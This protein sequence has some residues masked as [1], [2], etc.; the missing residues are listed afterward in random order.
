MLR[1][2]LRLGSPAPGAP[3]AGIRQSR[4]QHPQAAPSAAAH[5][6]R[7]A[8][9][10]DPCQAPQAEHQIEVL[11]QRQRPDAT[12]SPQEFAAQQQSLIAVGQL[13]PAAAQAHQGLQEP[14]G[15][16]GVIHRQPEG[17]GPPGSAPDGGAHLLPPSP[18][19]ARVGMEEQQ[20]GPIA[21]RHPGGQLGTPARLAGQG[22]G[23]GQPGQPGRAIPTGPIHHQHL[24]E[25]ATGN[26]QIGQ[27]T[28]QSAGLIAGEDHHAEL[29]ERAT[30]RQWPRS[31]GRSRSARIA[32][33]V[34][35]K[36]S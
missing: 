12:G 5:P 17:P 27:Q 30:H 8:Q 25:L 21:G 24:A 13:A 23:A 22:P 33:R 26:R 16:A 19:K 2:K 7:P 28:R 9:Q 1:Q 10:A 14:Q 20:P 31:P 36:A 34:A 6:Q 4:A 32:T 18:G 29:G 15:G 35:S 3:E 11:H